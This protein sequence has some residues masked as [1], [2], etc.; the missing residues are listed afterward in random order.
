MLVSLKEIKFFLSLFLLIFFTTIV[1]AAKF[2]DGYPKCWKDAENP[3]NDNVVELDETKEFTVVLVKGKYNPDNLVAFQYLCIDLSEIFF[4]IKT[5]KFKEVQLDLQVTNTT[6]KQLLPLI[7]A[8]ADSHG[9][10]LNI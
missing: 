8:I 5:K 6:N 3:V 4:E 9:I 10:E 1:Y 7:K 2:P